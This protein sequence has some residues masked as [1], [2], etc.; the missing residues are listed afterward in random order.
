M[1]DQKSKFSP[2]GISTEFLGEEQMDED[3]IRNV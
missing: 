1:M 3:I 2:K